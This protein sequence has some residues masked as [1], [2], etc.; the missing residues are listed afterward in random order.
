MSRRKP[1]PDCRDKPISAMQ[2]G[3]HGGLPLRPGAC[4]QVR[5]CRGRPPVSALKAVNNHTGLHKYYHPV[6][7]PVSVSE[8]LNSSVRYAW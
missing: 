3:N 2:A 5:I 6:S 1:I 7:V 8:T 4:G